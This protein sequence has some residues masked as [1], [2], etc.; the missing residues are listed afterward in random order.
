MRTLVTFLILLCS[1]SVF[2][3]D[4]IVKKNSAIINCKVTEMAAAEVKYYYAENPKLIFG[5]DNA[6]VEKVEF[7]TGEIIEVGKN[8]FNNP[9]YYA[10]HSKNALK[11]NFLS[12]LFGTTEFAYER[13]IKPGRSWEAA[14]GIVG[15]G[16][17]AQDIDPRGVYGKFSYK[18]MRNPDFYLTRMHY[19][20][21]L[22]GGYIAPEI[23]LR[24]MSYDE[25]WGYYYDEYDSYHDY[26]SEGR[27]NKTTLAILLK[28]GKQWV[29]DDAFLVDTYVG[30]G[31]GFGGDDYE[32]LPYGFIVA[33]DEFPIAFTAGIKIGWVFGK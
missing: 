25:N 10:N 28:F 4:R 19:S 22:K 3:Q 9:E 17:D 20:H 15:L 23:A 30:V 11:I 32:G 13:S 27:E 29:F 12:P 8:S 33:P 21:L 5:I 18:F 26:S 7:S 6:L 2:A 14:L 16:N 24:H 31:Y 1:I